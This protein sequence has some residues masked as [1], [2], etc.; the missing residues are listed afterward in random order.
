MKY[1]TLNPVILSIAD[2]I[3]MGTIPRM[4]PPPSIESILTPHVFGSLLLKSVKK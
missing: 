1:Y 2:K 3:L 4:E